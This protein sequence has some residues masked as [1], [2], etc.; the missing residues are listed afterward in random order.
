[1]NP[2][3]NKSGDSRDESASPPET[4]N[5]GINKSLW[6]I[7]FVSILLRVFCVVSLEYGPI[8]TDAKAYDELGLRVSKG[9]GFVDAFGEPTA[10]W[11]PVYPLFLAG[12]YALVGHELLWVR[13]IQAVLGGG[14]CV[15]VYL[16]ASILF[17]RR[18]GTL[19]GA[20]IAIYLPLIALTTQILT[21]TLFTFLMLIG[22]WLILSKPG[23]RRI[24]ISGVVL[25]VALLTK[26]ILIFFFP[27]F[28]YW[29]YLNSQLKF[30]RAAGILAVAVILVLSPWTARNYQ[31]MRAFVPLASVGGMSLYTA[32]VL[33][34]KGF[35]YNASLEPL[36]NELAGIT[37]EAERSRYLVNKTFRYIIDNPVQVLKLTA[38]KPLYFIYP[39]DGY[40]YP[41]SLG[42]KYNVFFG[43]VFFFAIVGIVVDPVRREPSHMLIYFLL[44]SYLIAITV[45]QG[46]PRYRLPL[47]PL[48]ICFAAAGM[49]W[50][51]NNHRWLF[52]ASVFGHLSLF[53]LL[54]FNEFESIF[55][56]LNK[57]VF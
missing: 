43:V 41:V 32:Y 15:L 8:E 23:Y 2:I 49:R 14:I 50:L 4:R 34:E 22:I 16:I 48:L 25:A 36:K 38:M 35:G 57:L 17:D 5:P 10:Y 33:P 46:L 19:G 56:V 29:I 18:I 20:I 9:M 21:E 47:D 53:A 51:S 52:A 42:S 24:A 40:W 7:L 12:V 54:R 26:A 39:F 27:F 1:M 55:S 6:I 28:L 3:E 37:N 31:K 44:L 11:P 13:I 30:W 45:F